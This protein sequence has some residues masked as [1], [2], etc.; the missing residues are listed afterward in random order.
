MY[1]NGMFYLY[2]L[3]SSIRSKVKNEYPLIYS[4][5]IFIKFGTENKHKCVLRTF[6]FL[7]K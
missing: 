7:F 3:F 5:P 6:Y 4:P 1:A 2:L